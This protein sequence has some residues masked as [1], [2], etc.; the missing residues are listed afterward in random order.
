MITKTLFVTCLLVPA[1][2]LAAGPRAALPET[3]TPQ[4]DM[5]A[6]R[7]AEGDITL[8]YTQI[9]MNSA[10][11]VE[12]IGFLRRAA[13]GPAEQIPFEQNGDYNPTLAVRHGA[14]CTVTGVRV[15]RTSRHLRVIHAVRKGDWSDKKPFTFSVFQLTTNDGGMG[16]TPSLY[17]V[18]KTKLTT[19]AAYCDADV[20]LDKEATLYRS[21]AD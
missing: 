10:H 6:I 21:M 20:A 19:K 14:D 16:G 9:G 8:L 12:L 17:F 4:R 11:D 1:L 18:E 7:T 13:D 5:T 3:I 2:A 15:L